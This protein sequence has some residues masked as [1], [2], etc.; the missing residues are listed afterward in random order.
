MLHNR[1]DERWRKRSATDLIIER[2]RD[3][4]QGS[5]LIIVVFVA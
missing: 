2:Q 4:G 1:E 5:S 3:A